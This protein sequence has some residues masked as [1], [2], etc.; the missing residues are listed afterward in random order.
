[1]T[2]RKK[3]I[4]KDIIIEKTNFLLPEQNKCN[5]QEKLLYATNKA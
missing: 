2:K 4:N 5:L 1:M 3:I